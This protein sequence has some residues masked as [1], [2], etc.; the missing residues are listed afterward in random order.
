MKLEEIEA[1][2]EADSKIDSA[3]LDRESLK[4]PIL[5]AKY[6]RIFMGEVRLLKGLERDY[7][8]MR[9]D[10]T[11]YYLGKATDEVYAQNPLT[12]RILRTDV[13]MYLDADD[14]LSRVRMNMDFQKAKVDMLEGFIKNLSFRNNTIRNAIDFVRFKN[15]A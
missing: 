15:G 1:E 2:I 11:H 6:Y 8:V 10:K 14:E 13:D 3:D 5:H 4:I 9:L 7:K 12:H